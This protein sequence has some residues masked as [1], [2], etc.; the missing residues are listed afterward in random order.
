MFDRGGGGFTQATT[1]QK[2]VRMTSLQEEAN[3]NLKSGQ[4]I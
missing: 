2:F 1:V 4:E 3:E